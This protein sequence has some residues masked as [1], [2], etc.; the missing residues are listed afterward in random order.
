MCLRSGRMKVLSVQRCGVVV[1][2][3]SII[4]QHIGKLLLKLQARSGQP[5]RNLGT[6]RETDAAVMGNHTVHAK[7]FRD[8]TAGLGA[9]APA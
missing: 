1:G 8:V 3:K 9:H 6:G 2:L 4:F 5:W 7:S